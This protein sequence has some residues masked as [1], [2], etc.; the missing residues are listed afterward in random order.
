MFSIARI[1]YYFAIS[2]LVYVIN[3]DKESAG[4]PTVLTEMLYE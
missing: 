4:T 1:L 3:W 2:S